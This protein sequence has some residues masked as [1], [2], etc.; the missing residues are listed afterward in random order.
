MA[1][2]PQEIKLPDV[3]E[4]QQALELGPALESVQRFS[5]SDLVSL[6]WLR[7]KLES[8][9]PGVSPM[10]WF[11]KLRMFAHEQSYLFLTYKQEACALA[12]VQR[13]EFGTDPYV[14]AIFVVAQDKNSYGGIR[15]FKEIVRWA[16]VVEAAGIAKSE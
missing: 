2:P 15:L 11:A 8:L 6:W 16:K 10:Q 13:D 14:V 5:E 1:E 3:P 9:F 4:Q 12:R 7:P